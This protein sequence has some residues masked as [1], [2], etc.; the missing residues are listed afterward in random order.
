MEEQNVM[1]VVA[2]VL[3]PV[4]SVD[5]IDALV[6]AKPARALYRMGSIGHETTT[7]ERVAR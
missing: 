3:G 6:L 2:K 5:A 7:M 4:L 1:Y